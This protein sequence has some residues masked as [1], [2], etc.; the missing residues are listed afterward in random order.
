MTA[1]S[2]TW[3]VAIDERCCIRL[4]PLVSHG[5]KSMHQCLSRGLVRNDG[6][7]PGIGDEVS[8]PPKAP[9]L[10]C[11]RPA[12]PARPRLR[13]LMRLDDPFD[14]PVPPLDGARRCVE[15]ETVAEGEKTAQH[16]SANDHR[17]QNP[18]H[19]LCHSHEFQLV[20]E[21]TGGTSAVGD[22]AE[23]GTFASADRLRVSA[24]RVKRTTRG[25]VGRVRH[26]T[27]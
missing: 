5:L 9:A 27:G 13:G 2:P 26:F 22:L 20:G 7:R 25:Q 1:W 17:Q 3:G 16:R 21:V 8:Q 18:R 15:H 6:G 10:G 23:G 19:R 11:S 24:P 4:V 12:C 14:C